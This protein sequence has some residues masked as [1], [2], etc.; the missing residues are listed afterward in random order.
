MFASWWW[1]CLYLLAPQLLKIKL[2]FHK[3]HTEP[4]IQCGIISYSYHIYL[5]CA[6][7][8]NWRYLCLHQLGEFLMSKNVPHTCTTPSSER[9]NYKT[10]H[11]KYKI[12]IH[13]IDAKQ[14]I[15]ID[16]EKTDCG[17]NTIIKQS[18]GLKKYMLF[19]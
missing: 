2:S 12:F 19:P 10:K 11:N 17:T 1:N 7:H 15:C 18:L 8:G 3:N 13:Y 6:Y 5:Y 14:N 9:Y 16:T 4:I